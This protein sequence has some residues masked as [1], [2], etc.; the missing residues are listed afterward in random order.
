MSYTLP[1]MPDARVVIRD[2]LVAAG[3]TRVSTIDPEN[4]S[5][6]WLRLTSTGGSVVVRQ[7]LWAPRVDLS[8]FA[9]TP[10]AASL[11]ARQ[12]LTFLLGARNVHTSTGLLAGCDLSV[13]IQDLTDPTRTPPLYRQVSSVIAYLRP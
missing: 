5:T 7:G 12:A 9:A 3:L 2:V 1:V 10:P 6:P 13:G 4:T 8:A 11:L